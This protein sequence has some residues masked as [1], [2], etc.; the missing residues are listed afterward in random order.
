VAVIVLDASVVIA[1]LDANDA[2]HRG[3]VG[4]LTDATRDQL[5]LPASAYAEVLVGA[6]RAGAAARAII[7][8]AI[9]ELAIGITPITAEIA[10]RAAFLRAAHRSLLLPDAL[11]LAAGDVLEATAVLTADRF[12]SRISRRVRLV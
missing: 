5:L 4:A 8:D 2:H 9:E 12:W 7:D 6:L 3:A 10:R 11:V 1:V